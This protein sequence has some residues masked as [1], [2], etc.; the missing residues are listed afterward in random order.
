MNKVS[1]TLKH[2]LEI[3]WLIA[4]IAAIG[5]AAFETYKSGFRQA[6]PFYLFAIISAFFYISRRNERLKNAS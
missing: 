4:G 6:V 3:I 2:L 1:N 5:I